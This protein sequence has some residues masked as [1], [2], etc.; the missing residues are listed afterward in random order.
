VKEVLEKRFAWPTGPPSFDLAFLA[1]GVQPSRIF[2]DSGIRTGPDGGLLINSF[3]QSV[4]HPEMFGRR[5]LRQL[6]GPTP[7]QDRS[8]CGQAEPILYHNSW[9][10]W[11]GGK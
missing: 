4:A 2:R 10:L 6:G 11:K 3:L 8:L 9:L 7:G 1:L 5:G